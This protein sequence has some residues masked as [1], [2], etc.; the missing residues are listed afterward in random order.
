METKP[1]SRIGIGTKVLEKETQK[2]VMLV[3]DITKYAVVCAWKTDCGK[4][5]EKT[6]SPGMCVVLS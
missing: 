6:L 1:N 3:V 4:V 5:L 2:P